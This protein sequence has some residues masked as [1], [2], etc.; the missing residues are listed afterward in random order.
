MEFRRITSHE[1]KWFG[2]CMELYEQSFPYIERRDRSRVE[3]DLKND[4]FH[5]MTFYAN[6]DVPDTDMTADHIGSDN[7]SDTAPAGFIS[8]WVSPQRYIYG[9]HFAVNPDM[10]GSGIGAEVLQHLKS[11]N[12]PIILEIENPEDELTIR[13]KN[14]YLRN[15]FFL[16]SHYH[17]QPPYHSD[18]PPLP[19]KIMTWPREFTPEEYERLRKYQLSIISSELSLQDTENK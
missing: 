6:S 4:Q 17:E 15:G 14:F 9:E 7:N 16:N 12:I 5:F 1:D 8:Y 2:Y 19:M 10:R 3:Q 13:R 18:C 11:M